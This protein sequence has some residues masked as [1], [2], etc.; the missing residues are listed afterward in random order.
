MS[1]LVR[2]LVIGLG[3]CAALGLIVSGTLRGDDTSSPRTEAAGACPGCRLP[4]LTGSWHYQLQGR[5]RLSAAKVYDIDGLDT[6]AA[7]VS[8]LRRHKRYAICYID[9]GTWENWRSDRGRFP[10]SVL[11]RGNGWPGERWLDI[12]RVDVL[13]PIIEAG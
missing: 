4:P 6:P 3:A 10:D 11:G 9:A 12:R 13:G 8:R 1:R 5:L 2:L 7:F